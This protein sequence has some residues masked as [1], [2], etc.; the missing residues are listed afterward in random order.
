[1]EEIFESIPTGIITK[2]ELFNFV[3]D[4]PALLWRIDIIKNKIEYLNSYKL[5]GL[6]SKS[7]LILQ[8]IDFSK[9]IILKEDLHLIEGFMKAVKNGE[10]AATIFRIKNKDDQITWIKVTGTVDRKNP[11]F[12]MGYMLD[13]SDTVGIVQDTLENDSD[14]EA[15]VEMVDNPVIL[16]DPHDKK[17]LSHNVAARDLFG[18]DAAEFSKL[19]FSDLY[20]HCIKA[21]INRIYE[22]VIFEKKWEG[23]LTFQSKNNTAF[24]GN[25][26]MRSLFL[27][28]F[29]VFRVS[30][31]SV[32]VDD[33][34]V[35]MFALRSENEINSSDPANKNYINELMGK[36]RDECDMPSILQIMLENQHGHMNFDSIIYSD[37]YARKNKVVVYSAGKALSAMK[38]GEVFSYEG[39]IAENIDRYK[40][41]YL[42]VEDTFSS[43]K[44]IDWALFI[45]HGLRSYFAKPFFDRKVI[46]TVLILCSVQ[47]NMFSDQHVADYALLYKPFLLGL[48]NWRKAKKKKKTQ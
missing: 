33:E 23:K 48:T 8:N 17:I 21:H 13:V 14:I 45:P 28:G 11:R 43:I 29:R 4:F 18:Y 5:K 26:V 2:D 44:A 10:T 38:Q 7:G 35:R 9:R 37:I 46:R 20:H 47:R 3:E 16:V 6:G 24:L 1:M 36:L 41:E 15:M 22:E 25:V 31:D 42:I 40:L 39:T 27:R 30:I 32:S 34:A 12:Y 19:K